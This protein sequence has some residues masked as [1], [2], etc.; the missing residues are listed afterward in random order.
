[1]TEVWSY[2][3]PQIDV[4]AP[5]IYVPNFVE[6]CDEYTR[7]DTPLFIPECATHSYAGPRLVYCVGHYHAMCYSPFGF[8]DMGMP[9]SDT[10]SYLFGV[11][12]EDPA[13]KTPMSV[14]EYAWYSRTLQEMM[15]L[16]TSKYGTADLQAV[17]CE[18]KAV[19]KMLFGTFGFQVAL[20]SPILARKDSVCLIMKESEDTFYILIHAAAFGYFS[21]DP[22]RPNVDVLSFE[23]GH[24][25][26]GVWVAKRRLN[27]DEVVNTTCQGNAL[28]RI[29]LFAYL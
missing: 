8:E 25:E 17:S 13:L 1:M 27:G 10:Q 7:R 24:F 5:D 29:Q 28:F 21:T 6:I 11:D 4:L 22:D 26:K 16:L 23:N 15:P 20:D 2:S 3:A 12:V 19:D 14:E 18:R 9:F